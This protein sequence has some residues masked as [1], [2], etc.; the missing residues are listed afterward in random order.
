MTSTVNFIFGWK[1]QNW[2]CAQRLEKYI[3]MKSPSVLMSYGTKS[4][5]LFHQITDNQGWV[6]ACYLVFVRIVNNKNNNKR[7]SKWASSRIRALT[8]TPVSHLPSGRGHVS[9]RNQTGV[10]NY[11]LFNKIYIFNIRIKRS[12]KYRFHLSFCSL[13]LILILHITCLNFP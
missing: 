4:H 3:H 13:I 9:W 10:T 12:W 2:K 6:W 5:S 11:L 1:P 8:L 7:A